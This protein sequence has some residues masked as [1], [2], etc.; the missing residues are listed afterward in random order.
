MPYQITTTRGELS[1]T[2]TLDYPRS[3]AMDA[4]AR[5]IA[6]AFETDSAA[7]PSYGHNPASTSIGYTRTTTTTTTDAVPLNV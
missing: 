2:V 6:F 4:A 1:L 7:D 3:D 5:E